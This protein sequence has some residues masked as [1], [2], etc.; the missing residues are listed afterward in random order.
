MFAANNRR[1]VCGAALILLIGMILV[2]SFLPE[3]DKHVLHTRGRFHSLGHLL[4][5]AS[6]AYLTVVTPKT[7]R[8]KLLLITGLFLFAFGIEI[9]ECLVFGGAVEWPDV[10][11]DFAGAFLGLLLALMSRATAVVSEQF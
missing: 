3:A 9:G 2:I 5:F 4:A 8:N 10:L 6:L 1:F 11:T 7:F